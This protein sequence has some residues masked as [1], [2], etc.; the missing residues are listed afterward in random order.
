[1]YYILITKHPVSCAGQDFHQLCIC[2]CTGEALSFS[3]V[4][5]DCQLIFTKNEPVKFENVVDEKLTNWW[6]IGLL[7]ITLFLTYLQ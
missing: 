4:A 5:A 2:C 7:L 6:S 1:M 3:L